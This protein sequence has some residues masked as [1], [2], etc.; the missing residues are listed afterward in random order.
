[1][2]QAIRTKTTAAFALLFLATL[3]SA[4]VATPLF[5]QDLPLQGTG[6][7]SVIAVAPVA[8][9]VEMTATATGRSSQLGK[10]SRHEVLVLDPVSGQFTGEVLFTAANGDTLHALVEGIFVSP[11]TATGT[12]TFDGG[13]GRFGQALGEASF[14]I[15]TSDGVHFKVQ[16][17][18]V[19][20]R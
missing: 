11:T 16:F 10:F 8:D 15:Y 7:G 18:G 17:R 13:S 1:M 9:G 2:I 12:Y 5:A 4:T 20:T 3:I 14:V 6:S 19:V